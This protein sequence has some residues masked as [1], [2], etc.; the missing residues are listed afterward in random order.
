MKLTRPSVRENPRQVLARGKQATGLDMSPRLNRKRGV[1][2]K[3]QSPENDQNR[4]PATS[5]LSRAK[6]KNSLSGPA[7]VKI[8]RRRD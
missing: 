7:C 1:S 8:S 3:N 4:P 2:Q 6:R 5:L